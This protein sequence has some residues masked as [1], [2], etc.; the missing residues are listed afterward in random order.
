MRTDPAKVRG[1]VV[2]AVRDPVVVRELRRLL[3]RLNYR[4]EATVESG[5]AAVEAANRLAPDVVLIDAGFAGSPGEWEDLAGIYRLSRV[6]AVLLLTAES[7]PQAAHT[8]EVSV[9]GLLLMPLAEVQVSG[10][11]EEAFRRKGWPPAS[12]NFGTAQSVLVAG[13][14]PSI[15]G[16]LTTVLDS[17]GYDVTEA[18]DEEEAR[19]LVSTMR[20]DLV[21]FDRNCGSTDEPELAGQIL[22]QAEPARMLVLSWTGPEQAAYAGNMGFLRK[23]FAL[24]DLLGAIRRLAGQKG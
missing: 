7:G 21:V 18:L 15:R 9:D 22:G 1:R 23:P 10:A 4:V 6:P 20:F 13:A 5:L 2:I 19:Q 3:A 12:G 8:G 17:A 16:L 11:L 14:N 24:P